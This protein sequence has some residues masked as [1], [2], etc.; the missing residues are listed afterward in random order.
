MLL[1]SLSL[2]SQPSALPS[3]TPFAATTAAAAAVAIAVAVVAV[4]AG[5][6]VLYV[7][8]K[9][10]VLGLPPEASK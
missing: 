2:F 10:S 1:R 3:P 6:A 4:I 7:R 5:T 8:E 9:C